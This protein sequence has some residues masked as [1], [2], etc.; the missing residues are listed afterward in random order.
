MNRFYKRLLFTLLCSFSFWASQAQN[1]QLP[2][3][4]GI[5]NAIRQN[6]V[7]DMSKYFDII[8]PITMNNVQATYS[9]AQA[10]LVL[11]DFFSKNVPQ[12]INVISSGSPN[13]TSKFSISDLTTSSGKYTL[14]ILVKLKDNTTYMLQ[15]IRLN[16]SK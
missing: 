16:V 6:R 1:Q 15:E 10:E 13:A 4:E 5:V 14:Y 12:D 2:I 3:M 9:P 8:V 7:E 11:K